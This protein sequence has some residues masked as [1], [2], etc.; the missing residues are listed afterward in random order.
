MFLISFTCSIYMWIDFV[1]NIYQYGK[2]DSI[3]NEGFDDKRELGRRLPYY[4]A[5]KVLSAIPL[6]I[7]SSFIVIT[8]TYKSMIA[9]VD[10]IYRRASPYTRYI[11]ERK[12]IDSFCCLIADVNDD[13]EILYSNSDLHYVIRLLNKHK[14]NV[15]DDDSDDNDDE[16]QAKKVQKIK[17]NKKKSKYLKV[18]PKKESKLKK[19]GYKVYQWD[20]TF[21]FTSRYINTIT[22]AMVAL[23]YVF[24][25]WTYTVS[26]K[27]SQL[28]SYIPQNIVTD[29]WQVYP[30]QI[31]CSVSDQ[32]CIEP[33]QNISF[34]W[35]FPK[36]M[37]TVVNTL[38]SSILAILIVPAFG[39]YLISML[40]VFFLTRETKTY[41]TEMY[42]GKCEFVR[43][44]VNLSKNSIASSSFHFG[45][46][47]LLLFIL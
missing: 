24:L 8:L 45:G 35:P 17:A 43:K 28:V 47:F 27:V 31:L 10:F 16:Q 4:I 3:S 7:F 6:S 42:K 21:R 38:R 22:V 41:L 37:I 30:G 12:N 44:A 23:Y 18:T 34:A 11:L 2:C 46:Y 39:A 32:L 15:D 5:Y 26:M 20:A 13:H 36:R 33:L 9:L 29:D 25:F 14:E 19:I 40:Q 1:E